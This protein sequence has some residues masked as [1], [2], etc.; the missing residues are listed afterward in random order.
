MSQMMTAI[1]I[2]TPGGPEVLQPVQR[3]VPQPKPGQVLIKVAAAGVNRPDVAQRTGAYPPPPGASDLPGLEVAGEIVAGDATAGGFNIGDKVCALT[4]GG[5]YSEYCAVDARHCLPIPSA[6]SMVEA[7]GLPETFFTAWSN[8]LHRGA[9]SQ[10]ESLLLHAG[11]SVI[12]ST[13]IP[14]TRALGNTVYGTAGSDE[15]VAAINELGAIGINYRSHKFEEFIRA[16]TNNR[17][18]DVILDMVAGDYIERDIRCLADDGRIVVIALLGGRYGK[19]DC[20]HLMSRRLTIT[21]STLRPRDND[22]KAEVAQ[23][24]QKHAWPLIEEGKVKPIIH[25]TFPLQEAEQAHAMMDAGEQIGKI[26]M[27]V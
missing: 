4:P 13:A 25:A 11:A 24:L 5:G 22:F 26:I 16:D 27:T 6:Y 20:A 1:E 21:G 9:L 23:N 17:G 19:I 3:P 12:G 8:V 18:V 7:A 15:R 2:T 14:L 10:G